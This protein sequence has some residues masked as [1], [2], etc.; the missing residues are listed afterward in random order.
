M[1]TIKINEDEFLE[2][3]MERVKFWTDD[4]TTLNLFEDMYQ[5]YIDGGVFEGSELDISVIVDNDYVNYCRVVEEGEEDF[6][7]IKK[8][9]GE[10]GLGDCS[11]EDCIGNFIEAV[12]SNETAFL[13]RY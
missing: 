2:M 6:E 9:Y 7:Q 13:I 10:Q 4:K 8:V 1:I 5:S 12:N 3:L 11:C